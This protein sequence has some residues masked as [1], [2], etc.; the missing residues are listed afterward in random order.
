MV[1][2]KPAIGSSADRQARV[3]GGR[4]E[5]EAPASDRERESTVCDR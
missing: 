1:Y 5:D 4:G 3:D 2:K